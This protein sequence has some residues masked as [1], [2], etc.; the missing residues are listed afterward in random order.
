[1]GLLIDEIVSFLAAGGLQSSVKTSGG[2]KVILTGEPQTVIVPI[3]VKSLSPEDS[4]MERDK[5]WEWLEERE[6]KGEEYPLIITEDRWRRDGG[7]LKARLLAHLRHHSQIYARNCEIRRIEKKEAAA[8]LAEHHAYGSASCRYHYGMFLKRH[9]GHIAAE[10]SGILDPGTL[11]AVAQFS[12]ARKWQKGDKVIRSYEWTRYASLSGVRVSGGMGRML[13]R[14]IKDVRP[15]DIMSYADLEWSR[16]DAYSRLGFRPEGM[17][18]GVTFVIAENTWE[19][20]PLKYCQN[21][22]GRF[23]TNFGSFKYRMKLTEY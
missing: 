16:G 8:F 12:N 9:T 19:R 4:I 20:T 15:D 7:S 13:K 1:M 23:L 14:F 21:V 3:E 6:S 17:K 18:E 10:G 11:V 2:R 22:R 5:I